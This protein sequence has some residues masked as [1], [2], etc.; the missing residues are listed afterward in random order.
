MLAFWIIG[1]D[2]GDLQEIKKTVNALDL[3]ESVLIM[4][5]MNKAEIQDLVINEKLFFYLQLSD[6]EGMAMSVVESMSMGMIPIVTP[7]G[8]IQDYIKD[9]MNG[10]FVDF[11]NTVQWDVLIKRLA[12]IQ[13]D[14]GF[15][16][17]R[18][19]ALSRWANVVT[20]HDDFQSKL[21]NF[22]SPK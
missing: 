7:V 1:P 18:R 3:S 9:G 13:N 16:S 8:Q 12:V 14:A 22:Y 21:L 15:D 17:I 19:S 4:G 5:Y 2:D 11:D 6:Y 20:Y 10:F